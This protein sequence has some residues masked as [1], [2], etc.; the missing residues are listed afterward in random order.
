[1]KKLLFLSFFLLSI[2]VL[3]KN[4]AQNNRIP[5][6]IK[7]RV[8]SLLSSLAIITNDTSKIDKLFELSLYYIFL[9]PDSTIFYAEKAQSISEKIG[10]NN[11]KTLALQYKGSGYRGKGNLAN[12][13]KY[14]K[15]SLTLAE[16]T[17]NKQ[18]IARNIINIGTIYYIM[19]NYEPCLVYYVKALASFQELKNNERIASS[20]NNIGEVYTRLNK[21]DSAQYFSEKSLTLAKDFSPTTQTLI[22]LNLGE[23]KFKKQNYTQAKED[24]LKA[25]FFAEKYADK[26]NLS[27]SYGLLA[28]IDLETNNLMAAQIQA[29]KAV[30]IAEETQIKRPMYLAYQIYS[31]VLEQ[32]GD[33]QSAL[34][35]KKLFIA[36]KD[37]VVSET[38]KNGLQIFE[39]EKTQDKIILLKAQ[40]KQENAEKKLWLFL[41]L[42]G[43]FFTLII[44][45]FV[46]R[47]RKKIQESY[48]KLSLA[49]IEIEQQ[50]EE[51]QTSNEE[52]YQI[53]EEIIAQRDLL[54]SK[55]SLLEQYKQKIGK[56]IEAAQMIQKATLP[57]K[58]K[59]RELFDEYFVLSRPKDIVSGDFWWANE[60]DGEKYLIVADCT[61]H[62]V[63]GAMLTMI[64]SALLD[65]IIRLMEITKPSE[66]L[67]TLHEEI[68]AV[69]QQDQNKNNEGMDIAIVHW[70]Y[71]NTNCIISFAAAKRPLY[72]TFEGKIEKIRGSRRNIGG[73]T[74]SIKPFEANNIIISKG[75]ALYLSSDGFADQ[76]DAERNNFSEKRLIDLLQEN[77]DLPM[78]EQKEILQIQLTDHMKGTEQRD[79]ILVIGVRL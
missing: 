12:A 66:I 15:E 42:G 47:S 25:V 53:Q 76:N 5:N 73:T 26:R 67:T 9:K 70:H 58:T 75:S 57:P 35:Y 48:Q 32:N 17:G 60:I 20:L 19:G 14:Y 22:W 71:E 78:E 37:S 40:Q 23:I 41:L 21:Y 59:M 6:G 74:N 1:M 38:S 65:R 55:N 30:K 7:S 62:G 34:K 36:Y 69:L 79:D 50:K 43:F 52:L 27:I 8:D 61:G 16:K 63:S 56:S 3:P 29:Q 64:G 46:L 39:Y 68:K 45:F 44:A 18:L 54:E 28:G 11:R 51:L 77:Q 10:D 72:H 24:L 2:F 13:L 49:K 4:Y 31:K 33:F